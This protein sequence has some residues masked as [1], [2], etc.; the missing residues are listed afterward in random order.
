MSAVFVSKLS[1]RTKLVLTFLLV[2]TWGGDWA[3]SQLRGDLARSA[4][5]ADPTSSKGC[6]S[7]C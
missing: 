3:R 4:R 2:A 7:I 6:Q 1:L 5:S